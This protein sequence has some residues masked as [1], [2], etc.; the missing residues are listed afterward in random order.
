MRETDDEPMDLKVAMAIHL[1]MSGVGPWNP[2]FDIRQWV[3]VTRCGARA[4][5]FWDLS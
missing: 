3:L 4:A 5:W 2:R 1:F